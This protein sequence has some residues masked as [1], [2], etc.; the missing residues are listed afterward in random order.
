MHSQQSRFSKYENVGRQG[1]GQGQLKV[2]I[3]VNFRLCVIQ[4]TIHHRID[5]NLWQ[6]VSKGS[7]GLT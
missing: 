6:W 5:L 7:N 2:M 3:K 1:H 4:K